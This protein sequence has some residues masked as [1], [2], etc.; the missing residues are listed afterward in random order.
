V[1]NGTARFR[2]SSVG[3]GVGSGVRSGVG[4]SVGR[5]VGSGVGSG[6]G[7]D[8]GSEVDSG[9]GSDVGSGVGSSAGSAGSDVGSQHPHRVSSCQFVSRCRGPG[10]GRLVPALAYKTP[11]MVR[12]PNVQQFSSPAAPA[13]VVT[14]FSYRVR[15]ISGFFTGC[16][17]VWDGLWVGVGCGHFEVGN[18]L[19]Y[20]G[21]TLKYVGNTPV[22]PTSAW[23]I[24]YVFHSISYVFQS[25][26]YVFQNISYLNML[27]TH[28]TS[29]THPNPSHN[30]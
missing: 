26:S 11:T 5:G 19:K 6:V 16:E 24:S 13:R 17:M 25:I 7:G 27:T 20:V 15:V 12:Q 1:V 21:N 3:S 2:P 18:T 28:P 4:S 14:R 10:A 23:S 8:V 29:Q 9:V 30:P 22:C